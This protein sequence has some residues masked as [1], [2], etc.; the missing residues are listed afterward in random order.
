M[1]DFSDS[2]HYTIAVE[3]IDQNASKIISFKNSI[4]AYMSGGKNLEKTELIK[5]LPDHWMPFICPAVV[6]QLK[7]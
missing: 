1:L 6:D 7:G 2:L 3:G 4:C 5:A